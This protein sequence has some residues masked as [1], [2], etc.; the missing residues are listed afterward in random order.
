MKEI[1]ITIYPSKIQHRTTSYWSSLIKMPLPPCYTTKWQPSLQ[2]FQCVLGDVSDPILIPTR[3]YNL[4]LWSFYKYFFSCTFLME[5]QIACGLELSN[6]WTTICSSN[7]NI[8]TCP[9]LSFNTIKLRF[10]CSFSMKE[11]KQKEKKNLWTK[12]RQKSHKNDI[13]FSHHEWFCTMEIFVYSASTQAQ[14]SSH[15]LNA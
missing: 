12:Q 6:S 4:L 5:L 9:S 14:T 15:K 7:S 11:R 10:E 2:Y 8:L 1:W 3:Y 13:T